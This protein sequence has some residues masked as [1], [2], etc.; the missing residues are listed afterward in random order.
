M[1]KI[2][3]SDFKERRFLIFIFVLWDGFYNYLL[4]YYFVLFLGICIIFLNIFILNFFLVRIDD[5][6]DLLKVFIVFFVRNDEVKNI[7]IDSEINLFIYGIVCVVEF[8]EYL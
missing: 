3:M 7:F 5:F 6:K 4:F 1:Y 2:L 8:F